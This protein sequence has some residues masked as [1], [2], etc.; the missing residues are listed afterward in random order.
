MTRRNRILL[1]IAAGGVLSGAGAAV[2]GCMQAYDPQAAEDIPLNGS[3]AGGGSTS[4]GTATGPVSCPPGLVC[5]ATV[6][7]CALDSPE[8]FYLCGSPLC[9][10]GPDPFDGSARVILDAATNPPIYVNSTDTILQGDGA[11]TAD[12]CVQLEASSLAIRQ[13]SCSPCHTAAA[14]TSAAACKC[15]LTDIMDDTTLS[16]PSSTSQSFQDDAGNPARYL[17]P[18]SPQASLIWERMSGESM[19]P[20]QTL[21]DQLLGLD[22]GSQIVYPTPED[23]SILYEWIT[24]CVGNDGGASTARFYGGGLNGSQ[25]FGPC[26]VLEGGTIPPS[27]TSSGGGTTAAGH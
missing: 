16:A 25:C 2:A 7:Q 11:T 20:P 4:T 1:L 10:I 5:T 19:P 24:S 23:V 26:G 8:C 14:G 12:P 6:T 15:K 22:A 27:I 18:G 9:A 21:A 13:R 17:I 3:D